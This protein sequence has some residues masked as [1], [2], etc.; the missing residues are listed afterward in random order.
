MKRKL[1]FP[2]TVAA[3]ILFCTAFEC[4]SGSAASGGREPGTTS[5]FFESVD[6]LYDFSSKNTSWRDMARD[7]GD[8][9]VAHGT[10]PTEFK[11]SI[12]SLYKIL[13]N[14]DNYYADNKPKVE[15]TINT[16][17]G[18]EITYLCDKYDVGDNYV[19]NIPDYSGQINSLIVKV[20]SIRTSSNALRLCWS[21]TFDLQHSS[22]ELYSDKILS[23]DAQ[24]KVGGYSKCLG[25]DEVVIVR[26]RNGEYQVN[27]FLEPDVLEVSGIDCDVEIVTS[28]SASS[29]TLEQPIYIN[30]NYDSHTKWDEPL[31]IIVV[32]PL[33]EP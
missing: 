6:L 33:P 22:W 24:I 19:Q 8:L 32:E 30:G 9:Y 7:A 18:D 29:P 1:I 5:Y 25:S 26:R 28:P 11:G 21:K 23:G 17:G 15:I 12:S 27:T 13:E 10:N 16:Y 3:F 2:L 20:E 31:A 4:E 14:S